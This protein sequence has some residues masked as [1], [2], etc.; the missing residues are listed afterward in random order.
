MNLRLVDGGGGGLS[1]GDLA[2]ARLLGGGR[3]ALPLGLTIDQP[4][5]TARGGATLVIPCG[6]GRVGGT[7]DRQGEGRS[8]TPRLDGR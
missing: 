5:G 6:D 2:G 8:C 3:L 1:A 4:E 7:G